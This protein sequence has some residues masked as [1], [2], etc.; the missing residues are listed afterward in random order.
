VMTI[1][2]IGKTWR[3]I[4]GSCMTSAWC[5]GVRSVAGVS[6]FIPHDKADS[7]I[8]FV[9]EIAESSSK[10]L[11]R[12][13]IWSYSDRMIVDT[14]GRE[15]LSIGW[16]YKNEHHCSWVQMSFMPRERHRHIKASIWCKSFCDSF[17]HS[18]WS[19]SNISIG[20]IPCLDAE[21]SLVSVPSSQSLDWLTERD[22][23]WYETLDRLAFHSFSGVN[24]LNEICVNCQKSYR[25]SS[26][27]KQA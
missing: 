26:K 14:S 15:D 7:A 25:I 4:F 19:N 17:N 3:M 21:I 13:S 5:I 6:G 22:I 24:T 11:G 12:S 8:H 2:R 9:H 18:C 23:R 1:D 10:S 16:R 27:Q 20:V